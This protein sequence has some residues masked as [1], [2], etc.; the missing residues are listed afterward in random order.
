MVESYK[1]VKW[2]YDVLKLGEPDMEELLPY[3][4]IHHH[5]P[6][7]WSGYEER[8]ASSTASSPADVALVSTLVVSATMGPVVYGLLHQGPNNVQYVKDEYYKLPVVTYNGTKYGRW[9]CPTPSCKQPL[10]IDQ[11]GRVLFCQKC[12]TET[13]LPTVLNDV[14]YLESSQ[15]IKAKENITTIA[16][17][18]TETK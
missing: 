4:V 7:S 2:I 9:L 6:S 17:D 10:W 11:W 15:L 12:N 1:Q 18:N 13:L 16:V 14:F 5:G 3:R 8:F